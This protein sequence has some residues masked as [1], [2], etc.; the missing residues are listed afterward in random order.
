[1]PPPMATPKRTRGRRVRK[2]ISA[3]GFAED[4]FC[5]ACQMSRRTGP[6]R[7]QPMMENA[8]KANSTPLTQII[9]LRSRT[10]T[11]VSFVYSVLGCRE[12]LRV[13]QAGDFFESFADARSGPQDL[14]GRIR[15]D[16]PFFDGGNRLEIGPMLDGFAAFRS[17]AGFDDYLRRSSDHIFIREVEPGLSS[18]VGNIFTA[19]QRNQLVDKIFAADG[20]QRPKPDEQKCGAPRRGRDALGHGVKLPG[21]SVYEF[22]AGFRSS[23]QPGNVLDRAQDSLTL[24]SEIKVTLSPRRSIS[25]AFTGSVALLT[26]MT[27]SGRLLTITS[28]LGLMKPPT[29]GSFSA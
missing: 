13:Y 18:V 10:F 4:I 1:M 26:P 19:R 27:R 15:I 6:S 17:H 28:R 5:K 12:A 29:L 2:N 20:D 16:A 7:A 9:F 22:F 3:S 24:A 14:V 25:R 11:A 8:S 21:D 23:E